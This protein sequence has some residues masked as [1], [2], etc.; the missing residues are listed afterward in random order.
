MWQAYETWRA[1]DPV[2]R[3]EQALVDGFLAGAVVSLQD[4]PDNYWLTSI[5]DPGASDDESC[6][7]ASA[8]I[9]HRMEEV[10]EQLAEAPSPYA[11]ILTVSDAGDLDVTAWATGF[12]D[13]IGPDLE[14]WAYHLSKPEAGLLGL[15]GSN[16]IG[17][18]GDAGRARLANHEEGADLTALS[19]RLWEFIPS[20]VETLYRKKAQPIVAGEQ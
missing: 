3:P 4:H 10:R 17:P 19:D 11:P 5:V 2:S 14:M 15:I 7:A 12:L 6:R 20:L 8:Q 9:K 18:V 1:I 13:A 16:A